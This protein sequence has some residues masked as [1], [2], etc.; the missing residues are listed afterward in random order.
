MA[1]RSS[2]SLLTR[3]WVWSL[4]GG[5]VLFGAGTIAGGGMPWAADNVC[6]DDRGRSSS[7]V[8]RG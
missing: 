2:P 1:K 3:R 4:I 7:A 6:G 5:F 8:H